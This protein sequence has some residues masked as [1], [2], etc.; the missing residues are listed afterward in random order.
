[1]TR[2]S[3]R[4]LGVACALVGSTAAYADV[5]WPALYLENRLVSLWSIL[6]GL[7]VEY[8]VL[9][10][11]VRM[12][13]TRAVFADVTMNLASAAVGFVVIPAAG[14]AWEVF[15][16]SVIYRVFNVG[17]FN[18]ITWAAT[19]LIAA[20]VNTAVESTILRVGFKV[21]FARRVLLALLV[22]NALSVGIAMVSLSLAPLD[23]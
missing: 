4:L 23:L 8:V 2:R 18:P 19:C 20:V 9:I 7:V 13:P 14:L 3:A 6:A 22:A 16:G 12:S 10:W 17:T 1:M 11:W 5:V 21:P 15:P